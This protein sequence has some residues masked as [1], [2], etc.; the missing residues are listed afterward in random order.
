MTT[1]SNSNEE[2]ITAILED[3]VQDN[4]LKINS[5]VHQVDRVVLKSIA[6]SREALI[7]SMK[8]QQLKEYQEGDSRFWM[9]PTLMVFTALTVWGMYRMIRTRKHNYRW[10]NHIHDD[11]VDRDNSSMYANS[12]NSFMEE[13]YHRGIRDNV[14]VNSS[15]DEKVKFPI[16]SSSDN[17]REYYLGF[18]HKGSRVDTHGGSIYSNL[19][20]QRAQLSPYPH[21]PSA[22]EMANEG[23]ELDYYNRKK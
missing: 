1:Y 5:Y 12:D 2:D 10:E 17:L 21:P 3:L 11:F 9:I 13:E 6:L 22:T 16:T 23:I 20:D 18:H 15:L 7:S 8:E 4:T 19:N 14:N